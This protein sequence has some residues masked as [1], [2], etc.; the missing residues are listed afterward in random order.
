MLTYRGLLIKSLLKVK[1]ITSNTERSCKAHENT[2]TVLKKRT[3]PRENMK[4]T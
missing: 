2:P 4:T 3:T 1:I